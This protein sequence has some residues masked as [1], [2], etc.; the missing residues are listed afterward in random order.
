MCA[1]GQRDDHPGD[2]EELDGSEV[3]CDRCPV[4]AAAR[5][6]GGDCPFVDR[7]RQRGDHVCTEGE[8]A[9]R[10]WFV[11]RGLVV[12]TRAGAGPEHPRTVR[13]SGTFVGLEALVRRTYVESARVVTPAILCGAPV[14]RIDEWLGPA[15]TPARMALEQT[16]R[17]VCDET[18][19]AAS[20]DGSALERVA[21]WLIHEAEGGE[22]NDVPR[23]YVAG[24]LGIVPETLSRCLARLAAAGSIAVTRRSVRIVD[25]AALRAVGR[26]AP[27]EST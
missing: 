13:R 4:R 25:L 2:P 11:K 7:P 23:R 26:L 21:R 12:L 10:V 5:S 14:A 22:I 16:L 6:L 24:L 15:G 1:A 19:R 8:P 17:A 27:A 18:P 9:S 3:S 20:A